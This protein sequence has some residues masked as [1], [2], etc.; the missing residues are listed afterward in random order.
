M[1]RILIVAAAAGSLCIV[2]A[3]A[4]QPAA[5]AQARCEA[6]TA[7]EPIAKPDRP[8]ALEA[9]TAA[10]AAAS[11]DARLLLL[12]GKA[13]FWSEKDAEARAAYTAASER[14]SAEALH[15]LGVLHH[16]GYGVAEDRAQAANFYKRSL[17]AGYMPAA[18]T[19]GG[20]YRD[21]A[22][23][24]KD[25]PA[26]V[27]YFRRATEAGLS[28][29]EVGLGH[30]YENGLGVKADLTRAVALYRS[31][32]GKGDPSAQ[33]NMGVLSGAGR[34]M[35][36]DLAEAARWYRLAVDGGNANAMFNLAI[37]HQQGLGV[38]KDA[39]AAEALLRKAVEAG[40][41]VDAPN[42]LAYLYA[43]ENRNLDEA[44]KLAEG[45]LK[46][47]PDNAAVLDTV[48]LIRMRQNRLTEAALLMRKSV[49]LEPTPIHHMRL[50]DIYAAMGLKADARDQWR[51]ALNAK[52]KPGS[53]VEVTPEELRRK[54]A[55]D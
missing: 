52:E 5:T 9:C 6:L 23:V 4:Q 29:G 49:A 13:L 15:E 37:A 46:A 34:G 41:E 40:D 36:K 43:R 11:D 22:G 10:Q 32:A 19:L 27:S 14:G 3:Q 2:S 50:G 38:P 16:W 8:A 25:L 45:A 18:A 47:A 48:A 54:L 12:K 33:F 20:L 28:A 1:K 53:E 51:R 26:A 24:P 55:A 31:A 42:S 21:G 39:A 7:K 44:A 35:R 30:L 17:D